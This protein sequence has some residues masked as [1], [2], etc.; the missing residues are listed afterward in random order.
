MFI[1]CG[2]GNDFFLGGG[3]VSMDEVESICGIRYYFC[4]S[5]N[6]F[7]AMSIPLCGDLVHSLSATF[8][9]FKVH[10]IIFQ[11]FVKIEMQ[12]RP[13]CVCCD[14]VICVGT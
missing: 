2:N 5:L 12:K 4:M 1:F 3:Y 7:F 14:V 8:A 9:N 6:L 10:V 13:G 11:I